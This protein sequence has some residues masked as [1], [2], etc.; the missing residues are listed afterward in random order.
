MSRFLFTNVIRFPALAIISILLALAAFINNRRFLL[1][2]LYLD[3]TS[4]KSKRK[5]SAN[6]AFL[7]RF[8]TVGELVAIDVKLLIRNKRPRSILLLSL[9]FCFY[10][11][12]FYKQHYI[13]KEMWGYLVFG[14]IFL[15]GI[16]ISNYG[17]FLFAWQSSHFDGLMAS[18]LHV[19]TYIKSKFL[20][21]VGISTVMFVLISLYGFMSW[22]LLLVQLAGYFFNIGIHTVV[23]VYFA[24]RSYKGLDLSKGNAFNLQGLGATQW[25]YSLFIFLIPLVLYLPLALLVSPIAGILTLGITGLV[26]F[27]LQDW[28][29]ELLTKEFMKRKHLILEGFREK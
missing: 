14:G 2:N 4:R 19:K 7:D 13:E 12:I 25:I 20:L 28:W 8:G 9:A 11:F 22:K 6:Y 27:L 23:A 24:T 26:S 21:F 3:D 29:T 1:R 5:Q 17:Q 15:T 10:G 18:H 16:F